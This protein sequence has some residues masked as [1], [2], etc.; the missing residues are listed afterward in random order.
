MSSS[1]VGLFALPEAGASP[2]EGDQKTAMTITTEKLAQEVADYSVM[3]KERVVRGLVNYE[4]V[5][6]DERLGKFLAYAASAKLEALPGGEAGRLAFWINA[7]NA[8][9]QQLIAVHYPVKSINDLANGGKWAAQQEGKTP[10]DV[11]FAVVAGKTYTLNEIENKVIRVQFK[12]PRIHFALVC[13]AL[14]CPLLRNEAY[15]GDRLSEQLDLQGRWFLSWRNIF[16]LEKKQARLSKILDWYGADFGANEGER[17]RYLAKFVPTE[18]A[19]SLREKPE[20]WTVSYLSYDWA[21][22]VK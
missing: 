6:S 16:E 10:W 2:I 17:L 4:A 5:K 15:V 13:A 1:G 11:R 7:Y 20:Q 14:G 9:T 8:Y 18:I 12:E 19:A 3:L 22:N 21:L